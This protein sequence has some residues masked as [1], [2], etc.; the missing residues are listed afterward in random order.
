MSTATKQ[1]VSYH[2]YTRRNLQGTYI[3]AQTI[4]GGTAKVLFA[5][6][7]VHKAKQAHASHV[8][9]LVSDG[10]IAEEHPSDLFELS[11]FVEKAL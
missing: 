10:G 5:S 3:V 8:A 1:V 9:A 11:S 6:G 7:N 2:V 4:D